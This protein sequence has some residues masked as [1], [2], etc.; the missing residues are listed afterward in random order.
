MYFI[1]VALLAVSRL[2]VSYSMALTRSTQRGVP[3]NAVGN[4]MMQTLEEAFVTR[5]L[6]F[7]LTPIAPFCL[8]FTAWGLRRRPEN[9]VDRWDGATYRRVICIHGRPAEVRVSGQYGTDFMEYFLA[10]NGRKAAA[11]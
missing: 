8:E 1:L 2:M 5:Q 9:Q 11:S 6:T 3:R 4:R 7:D 10:R